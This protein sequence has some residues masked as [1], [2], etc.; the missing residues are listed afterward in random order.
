MARKK[1]SKEDRKIILAMLESIEAHLHALV[2]QLGKP[3]SDERFRREFAGYFPGP[4]EE[5]KERFRDAKTAIQ[6]S[7]IEYRYVEGVG[8]TGEMLAWKN[9]F[10]SDTMKFGGVRR[11]F[12]VANS[13][14]GSLAAIFPPLEAVKEYKEIVEAAIRYPD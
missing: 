10:L 11:F 3:D 4:W 7:N 8:M 12:K 2:Q 5:I 1:L 14:I 9:G 6:K 13:I